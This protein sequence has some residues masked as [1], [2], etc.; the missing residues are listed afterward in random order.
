MR[1]LERGPYPRV[2][3]Y[4]RIVSVFLPHSQIHEVDP[5][6]PESHRRSLEVPRLL[7]IRR[8]DA[9]AAQGGAYRRRVVLGIEPPLDAIRE[10]RSQ[11]IVYGDVDVDGQRPRQRRQVGRRPTRRI[12]RVDRDARSSPPPV[13]RFDDLIPDPSPRHAQRRPHPRFD[14]RRA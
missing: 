8:H 3:R 2:L 14:R 11:A 6:P 10:F 12:R 1:V 7:R 13:S 5:I 4:T 9:S